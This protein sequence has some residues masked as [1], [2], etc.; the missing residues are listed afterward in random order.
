[1]EKRENELRT[2]LVELNGQRKKNTVMREEK[3]YKYLLGPNGYI[4]CGSAV[5]WHSR[6]LGAALPHQAKH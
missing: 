4:S 5:M 1:M 3:R 6:A 2:I